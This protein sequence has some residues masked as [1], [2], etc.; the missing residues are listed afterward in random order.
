MPATS[1]DISPEFLALQ[2]AVA[3]RYSLVREL[4]RGGMGI[5]FLARDVA[6]D[7]LVAIKLLPAALA[8]RDDLRERFLR[9]ARTAARLSHPHIVPIHAVEEHGPLV[10]FVMAFV[11]GETLGERIRRAGPLGA[12]EATRLLREVA[13][14]LGHAHAH[15]VVHR[16]VKPDNILIERAT[17]RAMVTDFGI[18]RLDAAPHVSDP[19]LAQGTPRFMSPEQAAGEPVDGRSD[20]YSLGVSGYLAL[21]GRAPFE[22]DGPAA[23]LVAHA[24]TPAP[25]VGLARPGLPPKLAAAIDRCLAKR[26]EDRFATAEAFAEALGEVRDP[27]AGVPAPVRAFLRHADAAGAEIGSA[28]LAAGASMVVLGVGFSLDD[29]F[30]GAVFYTI[31]AVLLGVAVARG[32]E[33]AMRAREL[34]AQGYD[35]EAVRGA[36]LLEARLGDE[37]GTARAPSGTTRALAV[38]GA[39][40]VA[41]A[42]FI[43]VLHTDAAMPLQLVSAAAA[44]ITPALAIRGASRAVGW[45]RGLWS[46]LMQGPMGRAIFGLGSLGQREVPR[47]IVADAEPTVVAIGRAAEE[48]YAALPAEQRRLLADVPAVVARLRADA[49]ALRRDGDGVRDEE[50]LASAAAA[51]EA[52]RLDLL[53]L[54]ADARHLDDLTRDLEAARDVGERIDR[55][56]LA[57]ERRTTPTPA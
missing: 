41:T 34:R 43:A 10:F 52:L 5:V 6:L 25:P 8:E 20:L 36:L 3:G 37:H 32:G 30:A 33:L 18:A 46:R 38:L 12:A 24:S 42:G 56:L 15:G 39:G 23:L 21:A 7:R 17:G 4:G 54:R 44:V 57:D 28:L 53:R 47:A 49:L 35:L 16:D 45:G 2:A 51:L 22:G 13:W 50:R 14:A 48:L 1:P 9:E 40:A 11:D 29:L 55:E 26:R 27:R 31:T 19:G